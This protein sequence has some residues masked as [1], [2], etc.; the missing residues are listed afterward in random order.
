MWGHTALTH[1]L[2]LEDVRVELDGVAHLVDR[3]VLASTIE[4]QD[5]SPLVRAREET[6][7][8]DLDGVRRRRDAILATLECT[9]GNKTEAARR[10]GLTARTLSNKM[11][12]WRQAG[13][14]S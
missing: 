4:E 13:F 9:R 10:L 7:P 8:D 12:I 6:D 11:K 14:V 2:P 1:G 3:D 5:F